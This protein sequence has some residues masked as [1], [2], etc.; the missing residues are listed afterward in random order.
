MNYFNYFTEIEDTFVRRRGKHLLLSPLD[1]AMI[2]GWQ[3]RG[4]PLHIV[5]R[6]IESVF[7]GFDKKPG[8]R[9]IKGLLYCREEIEAQYQEWLDS[10]TGKAEEQSEDHATDYDEIASGIESAMAKLRVCEAPHLAED[11]ER[12]IARLVELSAELQGDTESIDAS[13]ADIEKILDHALLTK[14]DSEH[15]TKVSKAVKDELKPYRAGMETDVYKTT[16]DLMLLKR[17]R[18]DAGIP[19]L[20]LFYL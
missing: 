12:V 8:A 13:L 20:G 15:L 2:E 19:R 4:I 1:W 16:F 17:L 7:D 10:Q 9:T 14:T 5:I 18:D 11:V 6:G 3:D